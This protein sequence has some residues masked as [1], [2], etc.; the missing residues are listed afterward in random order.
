MPLSL[1]RFAVVALALSLALAGPVRAADPKAD[2]P[3]STDVVS[4]FLKN[5]YVSEG[6]AAEQVILFPL[7]VLAEPTP[8]AVTPV[9]ANTP[10]RVDEPDEKAGK[11]WVK[12]SNPGPKPVLVLAGTVLEGGKRDRVIRHDRFVGPAD[13]AQVEV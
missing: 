13:V 1:A 11:E 3:D 6:L 10:L 4:Q 8:L 7:Y 9:I 2:A 12:V 5:L